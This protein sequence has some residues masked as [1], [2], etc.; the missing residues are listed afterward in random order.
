MEL[1]SVEIATFGG[2]PMAF[3]ASERGS[4]IGV[5]DLTDP[6]NPVLKQLLPS[7]VSPEGMVAI[8][9][10]NL[11]P[12]RTR[13]TCARTASPRAHDDLRPG[14]G[15]GL[16]SDDHLGGSEQ[17]IGWG[18]LSGLAADPDVA[19]RLYA[20]SDSVM[21]ARRGSTPSMPRRPRPDHRCAD[22]DAQRG[23][24]AEARLEGLVPDG[25]GGFWLASEGRS[26]RLIPHAIYRVDAEGQ[27]TEEIA[28]P[29]ELLAQETRFG[30]EGITKVGDVLWMAVQREWK[31][32]PKGM[33][34]LVS[35]TPRRKPGGPC[36]IRWMPDRGCL[37]GPVRD[38][39]AW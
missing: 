16:L 39:G 5:Y 29:E 11:L 38:H 13:S 12:P 25:E 32:D 7:G 28:L 8:P 9:Q 23:S 6:A 36:T 21:A 3:I 34:K 30:F 18:A 4:L 35:T 33:V 20:V 17:P 26:D 27:I 15:A 22:R 37:D 31:D 10:R 24:R 2:T 19:G 14:R 1:E